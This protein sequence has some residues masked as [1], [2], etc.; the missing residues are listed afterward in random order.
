M[1]TKMKI[2]RKDIPCVKS[3]NETVLVRLISI[4]QPYQPFLTSLFWPNFYIKIVT[5]T[6]STLCSRGFRPRQ[7]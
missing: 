2:N 3:E 7:G 1:T 4:N 5:A 6:A